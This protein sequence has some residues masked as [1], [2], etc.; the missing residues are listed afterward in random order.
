MQIKQNKTKVSTSRSSSLFSLT[1]L[2]FSIGLGVVLSFISIFNDFESFDW[3][4]FFM[5][6]QTWLNN[7]QMLILAIL[8][9]L[10][11][12]ISS[13]FRFHIL[14]Q[15]AEK[16]ISFWQSLR[17]GILARYYVLITPWG[18]GSQ[19]ILIG[20]MLQKGISIGK[21]TSTVMLDLL[22]MRLA[23]SFIALIGLIFFGILINPTLLLFAWIG[24]GFTCLFPIILVMASLSEP[25]ERLVLNFIK[26]FFPKNSVRWNLAIS[27]SLVQ[28]RIAFQSYQ[29]R[30]YK[31]LMVFGFSL[32]SQIALL[33]LSFFI[34]NAFP[35]TN[36]DFS[37][38]DFNYF[39]VLMMMALA[40]VVLGVAPTLGSAGAAEFTFTT[41]F[42][43]FMTGQSLVIAVFL[44]R[45]L[46]FYSW[47]M[48]GVILTIVEELKGK[49]SKT[50]KQKP[51]F[52]LPLRVF[53]FNDGFFPLIDGVVRAVDAYAR[54]L[55]KQGVDV[56]VVVPFTG[57]T[58][59]YPYK[60]VPI[61]QIKIPG[62][63]YP[64]PYG[65]AR[66]RLL[67]NLSYEG[68]T[69]YHAHTPFLLGHLALKL[70]KRNNVPLITTFHSKYYDDFYAATKSKV[71]ANYLKYLTIRFF[72]KSNAIWTV[73]KATVETIK[74]YGLSNR[75]IKVFS[76]GTDIKVYP[77]NKE[78]L[79]RLESTYKIKLTR[80][81]ILF[82]GQLI[83]Q[84]NLKLIIDT[85]NQL[86]DNKDTYQLIIVGEGRDE[87]AIKQYAQNLLIKT[88][89][90]FTG[91]ISNSQTLSALYS[92]ADLFFFPSA[93]DND[94]LVVK[95]AAAHGLPSLVLAGTSVSTAI[96][97]NI[98][99]FIQSGGAD[100][101]ANRIV[102]ILDK[103]N[104]LKKIG[105]QAK[106]NLARTWSETLKTLVQHYEEEIKK[107]YV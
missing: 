49:K 65:L 93:Y 89:I 86:D 87:I 46:L 58:S 57:D 63:F 104:E 9:F 100:I 33:S 103:P 7:Q 71:I 39:N 51:N 17:F 8:M 21:S 12:L 105:E 82:V 15:D 43:V 22:L 85:I 25:I 79:L 92:F 4:N 37:N 20:L 13:G 31:L 76:N 5:F 101:F 94:P 32:L 18:L 41:V 47:L 10:I 81:T 48:L 42:S 74:D 40:N 6:Q 36:F 70:S 29:K 62:F 11:I 23:M 52:N 44:W 83:W 19:P 1:F 61:P 55:V 99:G 30:V 97:N 59:Q 107:Y 56:T 68:P 16:S 95:E 67:K 90:I 102:K 72:S 106:I 66:P 88:P 3:R 80:I 84:K 60:I 24:F 35:K 54:F 73:S 2:L 27:T 34:L 50:S 77:E 69:I 26:I 14:T 64:L 75:E 28:Y 91:K 98:N 78:E 38:V 53:I 96:D 45:F